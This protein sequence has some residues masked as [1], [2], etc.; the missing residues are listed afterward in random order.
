MW[1]NRWLLCFV[2]VSSVVS[3]CVVVP[4]AVA[5]AQ[6]VTR[7]GKASLSGQTA[8]LGKAKGGSPA[9]G[10]AGLA[11][12]AGEADRAGREFGVVYQGQ[13]AAFSGSGFGFGV[14]R[15]SVGRS[16]SMREV[17][18]VVAERPGGASFGSGGLTESFRATGAGV[19]QSFRVANRQSGAGPLV[20]DVP[21][22]GLRAT[23]G[24]GAV[25]LLDNVGRIRATYSGLS[26]TDAAGRAVGASMQPVAQGHEIAIEVDDSGARY[27]LTVDPT[28]TQTA[29]PTSSDGASND[30]FAGAVSVSGATAVMGAAGHA[31]GGHSGEGSAYVFG[32]SAGTWSQTVELP[33]PTDSA[34][35]DHFGSAVAISGGIA[36]VG[37]PGHAV[38]GHS[39][40]GA[41]YVFSVNGG[42]WTQ[43]GELTASDG[44]A[45]DGFGSSVAVSGTTV[46][47]GAAGHATGGHAGQGAAYVYAQTGTTWPQTAELTSSDGAAGDAFG[48]SVAVS[49][50]TLVVGADAHAVSGHAGQGAAYVY[51]QSGT[52][53]PQT[54]ELTSSDGAASDAFG[55]SVSVSGPT[56]VV[57]AAAHAVS[58]HAGQGAAYVYGQ[59]GTTWPQTAEL[60]SSDGAASDAFGDSVSVSGPTVVVGADAHAVSGHADQ[61]ATYVFAQSGTWSQTS[62][63]TSSDGAAGDQFG[64]AVALSGTTVAVGAWDHTVSSRSHEGAAYMLSSGLVQPQGSALAADSYGGGSPSE[65]CI[66]C[67]PGATAGTAT[68]GQVVN[69]A[70]G[71]LSDT[72]TDLTLPG[73]GI[74]LSFTRTYDAQAAQAEV[75]AGSSAPALGYGWSDNLGVSLAYNSTTQTATVTEE[76]GAQIAFT[77]YVSGTSPAWCTSA[78]NYCSTAP[79]VAATLNHPS[80]TGPWTLVRTT[81]SQDTFTF[82]NAGVLTTITDPA[83]DTLA[84]TSYSPGT[85]QT[86]CPSANTCTV[87][88]SSASGRQLVLAVNSSGRLTEVFDANSTL[89]ATFAYSGTGCTTW[90]GSQTADLCIATDPGAMSAKYTYD[91]GN[92]TARF[93]YDLLSDT[94]PGATNPTTDT[95]TTGQITQVTDPTS[96]VT[97]YSYAGTNSS[98]LGGTTTVTAYPQGTGSGKPTDVTTDAYSASVLIEQ[99]TGAGTPAAASQFFQIDPA[100]LMPLW[101]VDG[102]GNVTYYT[103]QG[104]T[105]PVGTPVSTANVLTTNTGGNVTENA[106]NTFNQP[107]CSV[108]PADYATGTR[109]PSPA[110]TAPPTPG[111]SDPNLGVTI[112]YYNP[113]TDLLT[114]TTDPLGNTTTYSYTSGVSGVPNGLQYCSVDPVDY[115]KSA[116]CPAYGAA[117]VTGTATESFDSAGDKTASTDADGNTTTYTYAVAGHPG[118]VGTMTDPDG[119]VTTYG[120]NGAGEV[121]S[122]VVTFGSYS[123]TTLDAYDSQGR[124]YCQ[125]DAYEAAKGVTCPASAPSTPP[126]PSSDPYLGA[127]ITTYDG[128]GRTIQTTNPVGG[129]TYSGYDQA[130][131]N[132]CTVA[133][134]EAAASVTCPA[135][136][137][138][139][140]P[141]IGSD[142]YLGATITTYNADNQAVQVT[143]PLGGITL[144]SY[145]GAGN[146]TQT[147]VESNNT[148]A[149]PNV[150]TTKSY[151]AANRL[152][153]TTVDPGTGQAATTLTSYDPNGHAYCTVSANAVASG[154]F[155]CPPWQTGWITS[156]PSPAS[157]YSSTPTS[158]QANRVTTTF[159]NADGAQT[160]TTNPDV[161]TSVTALDGDGRTYCSADATNVAAWLAA[162]PSGVYPYVC[163]TSPPTTPPAQGSNPG[164][165]TTIFDPAGQT[166]SSTDQVGDTT[167]YTY[168][169][170]GQKLTVTDPRG[171]VTT[172][173]YYYQ[174]TTGA[175]AHTAPAGGG[176]GDDLYSTTTPATAADPSGQVTTDTYYPGD[177]AD[178]TTNP[179]GTTTD[180][181]DANGDLT[182]VAYTATAA[183]YTVPT[184]LSYTYNTDGS[185]HTMVDATGTTTYLYDANSDVTAKALVAT[186]GLANTTTSY[187]YYTTGVLASVT[188]PSYT[189]HTTPAVNYSYDATGAMTSETDWLGNTVG[190]GHDPDGNTTA[191]DNNVSMSNPNGTSNTAFA[192]DNADHNTQAASTLAQTCGGTETLNQAFSG[193]N[194]STNPDGQLTQYQSTY[195]GSCS[196]QTPYQRNYSYDP[197]GRV[198]YQGST[199]Q[200]SAP[201][202]FAYDP[203]GDPTTITS[204]DSAG[205]FD[206]YNQT[207]DPAGEI[208][209]QTPVP[210]AQVQS[211]TTNYT[212]TDQSSITVTLPANVTAGDAL[213]LM[214][215]DDP[216]SS[217]PTVSSVT[218]G[219]V[220]WVKG[221]AGGTTAAGDDEVWYG[222]GSTGGSGTTTITATMTAGTDTLAA[223]AAEFSGVASV[224]PLDVANTASGTS[225]TATTPTLTTTTPGDLVIE[226][227]NLY[228]A[229]TSSPASPWIDVAGPT[230]PGGAHVNPIAY[231]TD[232][233][234]GP[235][236]TSWSQGSSAPFATAAIALKPMAAATAQTPGPITQVQSATTNYTTTAQS[237]ITVTLPANVTAGDALVLM[238]ADNPISP[239]PTVSAV[240]G[241][242]V[243]WVKGAAGGSSATGDDEVWYGVGSSGGSGTT[244]ITATMT[245]GTD[246]LAAYAAEFS[247]VA[248]TSPLDAANTASGNSATATSPTLTTTIPGDLVFETSNLFDTVTSS[249]SAPWTDANGP[250]DGSY[251]F[252]PMAYRTDPTTGPTS[253]SWG[254]GSSAP[255]ATAAIALK[256]GPQYH[257][258]TLGDQ[259]N[260]RVAGTT[261]TTYNYDQTGRM[262]T[263]TTPGATTSYTYN[264]DNLQ[265]AATTAGTTAQYTWNNDSD[266]ALILTDS[267]NDYIYGPGTSPVEQIAMATSTPAYLTYNPT[268]NTWLSSNQA[269]D[270]TGY[271]A[272]DAFG[273]HAYG[274]PTTPFGYS[275]QYTDPTTGLVNDRARWYE[276]QTGGFS[277][278]DPLFASTD[279]A[280]TY[281]DGDPVNQTDPSGR[282]VAVTFADPP[283]FYG[284]QCFYSGKQRSTKMC[285]GVE[286][287]PGNGYVARA[288]YQSQKRGLILQDGYLTSIYLLLGGSPWPVSERGYTRFLWNRSSDFISSIPPFSIDV[289]DCPAA[290]LELQSEV[291]QPG[292]T[293]PSSVFSKWGI[294]ADF[295]D[296]YF[297]LDVL[298]IP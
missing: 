261:P 198:T 276:P 240:T 3:M 243:T 175:C 250:S 231:Q 223:Y 35:G 188:Y 121:T 196:G 177:Q 264:G 20:I 79:R 24:G 26:V 7:S 266:L 179:A 271:W 254:Q 34:A 265:A 251:Y 186:G 133:P 244:T 201:N 170:G 202:N 71:D 159:Y 48:D 88:T 227:S 274:T 87:W 107:W 83:G 90:T 52:T 109:C 114:A 152:I 249:P 195:T 117:H 6:S 228:N 8:A 187:S 206:T 131:N 29:E 275:G 74:P 126:T 141:T 127:T 293:Y 56:V 284:S 101:S 158:A 267:A 16:G 221:A 214:V 112:N 33:T 193:A 248:T 279:T 171:E 263:A 95:Y 233:T 110:P 222:V 207:F 10:G 28:W 281:A 209:Q 76:N 183:G 153:S 163:P 23:A 98:L 168:T 116:T 219:G 148:T 285:I 18:A 239:M 291:G 260:I 189:G 166:L 144:T 217:L 146:E 128:D 132:F 47:V 238:V 138:T 125:V 169:P 204:H 57:G 62:E 297:S 80:P 212:A 139:A 135:S 75:T 41:V 155:Q 40:Q 143:N 85:G 190:F 220:T 290:G 13:G 136:A 176:S 278:T 178:T 160:Q 258:D 12:L 283:G 234:T 2:A 257:Y 286:K 210:V 67:A 272:Y 235:I 151:D 21:V 145:D 45:G 224:S 199:A 269:G 216:S 60:T 55:N 162:H 167:S 150:V 226:T 70:T 287:L 63:L 105:A 142:P 19:E 255:W 66:E 58:G 97:T 53:W 38:G 180:S 65:P 157:L 292:V 86:T 82:T 100:S 252:N 32:A 295:P 31:T 130:G 81:G 68:T 106:Y 154:G 134:F 230:E 118:L 91:S 194:G 46:V 89:A 156:P 256:P 1:R 203:S 185:R 73:A 215:A 123:A 165:T 182:A 104:Y 120:Y 294:G 119:T 270:E 115:Q 213:V 103:Y 184:N 232:P 14:G 50:P 37:A 229:V 92:A 129:I 137:P 5:Q 205:N 197:A 102:D 241:G 236:S 9:V 208:T 140:P 191:Q 113:T 245:A 246:M 268:N 174:N 54:A 181:Y 94:T 282:A 280:Y 218:G 122:K 200:G 147:T 124:Q 42:T 25:G 72:V 172:D 253:T 259:T 288:I 237:S 242:G 11:R 173:C 111:A 64:R 17:A 96:A 15:S 225:A 164:Y 27:P 93:D 99:T 51:A 22:S 61:G 262:T 77:P 298:V 211:A 30:Q 277:T 149:D 78:T 273:T 108:D 59:S 49:G 4:S 289:N 36:V 44:A 192:Y 84:P 69:P 296:W 161:Q 43:A 247:G 39:G